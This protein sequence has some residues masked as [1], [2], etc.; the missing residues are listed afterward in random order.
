MDVGSFVHEAH[1]VRWFV[2]LGSENYNLPGYSGSKRWTYYRLSSRSHNTLEIG[3]K[4]Q[5]PEAQPCPIKDTGVREGKKWASFN[6]TNAY[7]NTASSVI[8]TVEFDPSNGN[9]ILRDQINDPKGPVIWRGLTAAD[10]KIQGNTAVLRQSGK[11]ITLKCEHEG[12]EWS[13]GSA[14]PP[15]S[16]E[17]QNAGYKALELRVPAEKMLDLRVSIVP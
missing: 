12:A 3:G 5:V 11:S 15:T 2:E 16:K 6:L 17:K 13:V 1:G 7:R 8:R 10:I 4:L 9:V 14:K